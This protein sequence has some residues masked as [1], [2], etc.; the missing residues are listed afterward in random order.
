MQNPTGVTPATDILTTTL[1]ADYRYTRPV[2]GNG[3]YAAFDADDNAPPGKVW[4]TRDLTSWTEHEVAGGGLGRAT[5][6]QGRFVAVGAGVWSSN[7]GLEWALEVPASSTYAVD[8][9]A[10]GTMLIVVGREG[11]IYTGVRR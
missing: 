4:L 2:L 7:D 10:A 9:V 6:A 11:A 1:A 8:I 5:F 3:L